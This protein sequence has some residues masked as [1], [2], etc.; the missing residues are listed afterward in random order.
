MRIRLKARAGAKAVRD[1]GRGPPAMIAASTSNASSVFVALIK[2]PPS[3][4]AR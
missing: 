2:R 1:L 3:V 4:H